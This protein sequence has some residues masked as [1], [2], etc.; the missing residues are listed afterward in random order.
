MKTAKKTKLALRAAQVRVLIALATADAP[1][2]RK[3]IA[4]AAKCDQAGLT[5]HI[6]SSDPEKRKA[7]DTRYWPSLLSRKLITAKDTDE[8]TVYTITA[9]GR[10]VTEKAAAK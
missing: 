3:Q 5:E 4:E 6:G 9:K 2:T 7:N 1:L 10:K 8:G